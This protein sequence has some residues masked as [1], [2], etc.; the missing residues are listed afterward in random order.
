MSR[1]GAAHYLL[2]SPPTPFSKGTKANG[3]KISF[4]SD[5]AWPLLS[6]LTQALLEESACA[7][8]L[9]ADTR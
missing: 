2:S 3:E 6:V 8:V 1:N 4:P 9:E 7:G 5:G